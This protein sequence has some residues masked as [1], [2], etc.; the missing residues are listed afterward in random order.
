MVEV[1]LEE[2]AAAEAEA[3][4]GGEPPAPRAV[5]VASHNEESVLCAA[6]KVVRLGLNPKGGSVVFAQ[7]YGMAE[8]ISVPLGACT[9]VGLYV[10]GGIG[11]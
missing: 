4:K 5:M 3:A 2:V 10:G 1:M 8:N 11:V 7:V 9:G 6:E